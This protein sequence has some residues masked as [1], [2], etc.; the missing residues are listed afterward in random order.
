MF[1]YFD[2]KVEGMQAQINKNMEPPANKH[3]PDGHDIKGNGN[4]DQ[5]DFNTEI[6]FAI[7]ECQ[8]QISRGNIEDLS[9]NLTSVASKL[10]KRNKLN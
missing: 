4:K 8:Q 6:P 10:K 9:T 2:K 5:F 1:N 3:K 7:T